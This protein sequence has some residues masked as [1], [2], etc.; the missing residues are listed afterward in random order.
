MCSAPGGGAAGGVFGGIGILVLVVLVAAAALYVY[1][2]FCRGAGEGGSST[3]KGPP[4]PPPPPPAGPPAPPQ[5]APGWTS[6]VDPGSGNTYYV[7]ASGQT[8]WD[9]PTAPM[10]EASMAPPPPPAGPPPGTMAQ[11]MPPGW[12]SAVDPAS[13]R[14]YYANA[15]T[16]ATS[17]TYPS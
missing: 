16:G 17:W 14:V 6:A 15:T 7:H 2:R 4:P 1:C 11:I 8:T 12:T 10:A 9:M 3:S 13:G 5:L